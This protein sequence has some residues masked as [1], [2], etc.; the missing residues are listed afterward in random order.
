MSAA[1]M[2]A[3]L[4][5]LDKRELL[6][7]PEIHAI[8]I[9]PQDPI[10]I[11]DAIT[12]EA[13]GDGLFNIA[14]HIADAGLLLGSTHII[15]QAR[16]KGWTQYP[17]PGSN[18]R[19][20]LMLP[21]TI[22]VQSLGLDGNHFN[23][24]A[25]AVTVGFQ[26]DSNLRRISNLDFYKSRVFCD[27]ISYKQFDQRIRKRDKVA[28]DILTVAT[29]INQDIDTPAEFSYET[30]ASDAVGELMVA[31][32]RLI[33]EEMSKHNIPWLYRNH[34]NRVRTHLRDFDITKYSE[35]VTALL[36]ALGR[37]R[38]SSTPLMHAGLNLL[39]YSHTTSPLRR[40]PDLANHLTLHALLSG[41]ELPFTQEEL[42]IIASE[43]AEKTASEIGA[44]SLLYGLEKSA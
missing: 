11:D 1:E 39:P 13:Q 28:L 31:A 24:G 44:L 38:Y 3:G 7:R 18:H 40:F 43:L 4:W 25:P 10:E 42:E 29:L 8:A 23:L 9:D 27:A 36:D 30:R 35:T 26:F 22:A 12:C 41:K 15:D 33:A 14:I 16:K 17:E 20:D 6:R 32:N 37:G 5:T 19:P 2:Q 21:E 34:Q